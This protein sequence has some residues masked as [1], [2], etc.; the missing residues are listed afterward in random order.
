MF[1]EHDKQHDVNKLL[2]KTA[3]GHGGHWSA[4]FP[5]GLWS[6]FFFLTFASA[7]LFTFNDLQFFN[8]VPDTRCSFLLKFS[9]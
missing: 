2:I 5:H 4:V 8:Q 6:Q 7:S 3:F 9:A 1:A